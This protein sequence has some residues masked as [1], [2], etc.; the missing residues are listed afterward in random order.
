MSTVQGTVLLIQNDNLQE[1]LL[2]TAFLSNNIAVRKIKI[3]DALLPQLHAQL[4][5]ING[6]VL[7]CADLA[8]LA[9]DHLIW[10]QFAHIV[11]GI[12][13]DIG[14]LATTSKQLLPNKFARAWVMKHG[15]LELVGSTSPFRL[16][17]SIAPVLEVV[18]GF[19]GA[20]P[21]TDRLRDYADALL[22]SAATEDDFYAKH[23]KTWAR[24]EALGQSPEAIVEAMAVSAQVSSEDRTYMLKKYP[25]CFI[26][27]D[28]CKWLIENMGVSANQALEIGEL[29]RAM[30]YLYHVAKQQPFI[31]GN[32][33]Y[34]FSVPSQNSTMIDID[35]IIEE[36]H[37]LRGFDI[38]DRKWRGKT[39]EKTFVGSEA[40]QWLSS[41]YTL[42]VEK[43]LYV[44]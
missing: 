25:N 8:R 20:T 17:N 18:R 24:L 26:G 36:G 3:D 31:D 5:M 14:L 38:Q 32:Y 34:R 44:G 33:F 27:T 16:N 2:S 29:L 12:S 23:H 10:S 19:F 6:R 9:K 1:S 13:K 42:G 11:N 15:G 22:N 40:T 4:A 21:S 41:F 28:A 43:A 7:I 35:R 37:L 39:F 30:G